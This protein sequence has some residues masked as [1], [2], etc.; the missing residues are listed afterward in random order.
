M[1]RDERRW[2]RLPYMALLTALVL[3]L[4]SCAHTKVLGTWKD[5]GHTGY[6][7]K[8]LV[9]DMAWSPDVKAISENLF[10]E[11][12]EKRGVKAVASHN[13]VSDDLVVDRAALKRIVEEQAIDTLF[14]GRPTSRKELQSLRPGSVSYETGLYADPDDGFYAAVSGFVYTPGTYAEEEVVWELDLYEVKT[15]KRVWAVA[16]ETYVTNSRVEEIR[17]AVKD[18][19]ERLIADKMIP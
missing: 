6:P 3:A 2:R 7:R 19:M 12:F 17:P 15:K 16:S 13:F 1:F 11:E 9:Y 18:I 4:S 8:I 14:I 5:A 10:V